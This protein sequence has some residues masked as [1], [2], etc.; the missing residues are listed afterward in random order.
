MSRLEFLAKGRARL[1]RLRNGAFF[2][3]AR[4]RLLGF[5]RLEIRNLLAVVT[6]AP[7]VDTTLYQES[8]R[9]LANGLG[10]SIFA[11]VT[12]DR[13]QNLLRRALLKFDVSSQIPAGA[14]INSV[15]LRLN[16]TKTPNPVIS[17]SM[18][19]HEVLADWGEGT[20]NAGGQ[21]GTGEDATANSATWKHRFFPST[22]WTSLGGDFN[23]KVSS[24]TSVLGLGSY[25]WT[26]AGLVTDVQKW[27][28]T[29]GSQFG[30][31]LKATNET[32]SKNAKRFASANNNNQG[33]RP[34]L[35]VDFTPVAVSNKAPT[36]DLIAN[37]AAIL[38]DA[39]AQT[40]NLTGISAGP[41]ETQ[42]LTVTA[43]SNNTAL[44]PNPT[45]SYTSPSSTGSLVFTPV[46]NQS[47]T[48]TITVTVTDNGGT[49]NG[50]VD[51]LV[52]SFTVTVNPVNDAPTLDTIANPTAILEEAST[53][54]VNLTGISAGPSENQALSVTAVSNNTALIANPAVTYVSPGASG[55]LNYAPLPN[56]SGTAVITVT[57]ADN[58]GTANGGADTFVRS[59]TVTVNAVND[60]PALDAIANPAAI[61]EDAA[62]Q[63]INLSGI[64]A[65]PGE[66]Q[67]LTI[68]AVSNNPALIPNPTVNYTSPSSTGS[69]VF[70]PVANQSGTATITVTV[71]DNG[72]TANGGVESL[73]RSFT[74]T[75]NPVNDAPTLDAIAN[76]SA[77]L[78]DASAQTVNLTGISAGP[79][80]NQTITVSAVSSNT[81]LIAN[82]VVTYASPGANGTLNYTPIS[83]QFGTSV[84]TV[85]VADNGG[86]ANGG[87]DT[88]VRSFT[89]TVNPVNDAPT[90]D[91]IADPNP[92]LEDAAAQ[93][94]NLAGISAGPNENQSLSITAVSS[95]PALI[96]N[97][98]VNFT[99]PSATGTLVYT[100]VANQSGS[101]IITVTVT[102]NGGIANG[103]SDSTV[104]SF[105]VTVNAVN[106]APTL[107]A[108]ANP[109]AILEDSGVQT[110]NLAGISAGPNEA[111][112]LSITAV[113]NNPSLIPNPSVSYVSPNVTGSLSYTPVA[114]QFGSA[115]IVVTVNDNGGT[116][117]NGVASLSRTFTVT[118]DPVNDS[119]TLDAISNPAPILEDATV[120]TI[121]LAGIG[122]GPNESQTVSIT[123]SSSNIALIANP[124]IVYTSPNAAG[125]L[126]YTPVA[127]QSGTAI[128]TVTAKDS[129]GTNNGGIDSVSRTFTVTVNSVNDAPTLDSIA[130]P[131]AIL[132]DAKEQ[133]LSLAG[134]SA[135]PNETQ[136][137]SISAVS[138]NPT[139]IPNPTVTYVSPNATGSLAFTPVA[140]Q[141]GAATITVTVT[142]NGGTADNGQNTFT[143]TFAV[144]VTPVN[145]AP[146]LDLINSPAPILEN[147][148]TQ[149]VHLSGISAGPIE[150]Q[151][152][153]VTAVSSNPA[154]TPNPIVAYTS[155]NSTG[156]LTYSPVANQ[157]GTAT[158]T[159]TV[160]DNGGT[161]N[162]GVNQIVRTFVVT[163][164]LVNRAPTLDAVPNPTAILEDAGA[165]TVSLTGI[166]AG[167][168]ETQTITVSAASSNPTLIPQ[169][170]V[171]YTSPGAVGSLT[172]TPSANQSGSAVITV[173]VQ[174]NGGTAGGGI[175]TV[176]RSFTVSVEPV[177]DAPTLDAIANPATVQEGAGVQTIN[178]SGITAGPNESQTLVITAVSNNTALIP[179]PTVNYTSPNASGSLTYTPVINQSGS[180]I[181]TVTVTDNGGKANGGVD[182]FVRT[183]RVTVNDVNHAPTLDAIPNPATIL[184]DAGLQL[185]GLTGISAG[186]DEVQALTISA[187]SS[188]TALI[189]HPTVVY[190]SPDSKG[191][192]EFIPAANQSGTAV[193]TVTLR[194]DGGTA[195]GGVDSITRSFTVTVN[196]VNDAPTL[197]AIS[198]PPA[199]LEGA[200]TQ[201]IQMAGITAGPN[202]TQSLKVSAV[203]SNT[204]LIPNPAVIYTS[205]NATGS[206]TYTPAAD[207]AGTA[208]I[209]VT[210]QD[211]GGTANGGNDSFTRTFTVTVES[212]ND[213]PTLDAIAN[214]AA[215][216]EDATSQT[217]S[218]TGIS[219]GPNESQA[220]SITAVSSNPNLISNPTVTY[221]SPNATASLKYVPVPN[222]FGSATIS[223]TLKDDGG[224]SNGG[225]D[226][227]TRSFTI[228]VNP[229]NDAPT[230]DAIP[231]P[232]AVRTDQGVQSLNLAGISAGPFESQSL[233]VSAISSNPSL[234]GQPTIDYTSPNAN[235]KLSFAPVGN[236]AGKATITVTV[237]D[238]GGTDNG[239]ANSVSRDFVVEVI[240]VN[241]L[242]TIDVIANP[243]AIN[244]D[245]ASQKITL[246][247]ITAGTGESQ[248]IFIAVTSDNPNV[249]P[250]PVV[251]YTSPQTTGSLAYTPVANKFGSAV[252]TVTVTDGGL[253]KNLATTLDNASVNRQF[254]VT[255]NSVNDAPVAVADAFQLTED[256]LAVIDL[257]AND[258]DVDSA[259]NTSSFEFKLGP[260]HG[261]VSVT[262]NGKVEYRPAQDYFG[263]DGFSY[264]VADAQG[265]FSDWATVNL[266][267]NAIPVAAGELQYLNAGA[268]TN[269]NVLANDRDPDGTAQDLQIVIVS[270][271]DP[272]VGQFVVTTDKLVRF[273]PGQAFAGSVQLRY[274]V[275]DALGAESPEA[276]ASLGVFNQN[277]RISEDVNDSGQITPLDVLFIINTLNVEGGRRIAPGSHLAPFYDVNAD[278]FV[279]PLDALLIINFLNL[280]LITG[281]GESQLNQ[282]IV[283]WP[284]DHFRTDSSLGDDLVFEAEERKPDVLDSLLS[285]PI[286]VLVQSSNL[287][288][289]SAPRSSKHAA[290]DV[291]FQDIDALM[292][293]ALAMDWD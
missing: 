90:L 230:L 62:A 113:S 115:T 202:E 126:S 22:N 147:S 281:E 152:L 236:Q 102:D 257:L 275:R 247:G 118:V 273:T 289:T 21:E 64:S 30:W 258:S 192:L 32:T 16:L 282:T 244:E 178:L 25:E 251:T 44:I 234:I 283:P 116:A 103:G 191:N 255:V 8:E 63:T 238:N 186:P 204:A 122:A 73:V 65:G 235:G 158:I 267:I 164:S 286:H 206:L 287:T 216:L 119:P 80:E 96:P 199:I 176:T 253:D 252:I 98:T 124:A 196:P 1:R 127:N 170:T 18:S 249:I 213:V 93:T 174:D 131:A 163:V 256:T 198:D 222:Q 157:T 270:N 231:N 187:Q 57:V 88:F 56:Q 105:T 207:Q 276:I 15:T 274:R 220:L 280:R 211:D 10:D 193:I 133:T 145:D 77:T 140:N 217:V 165:Q 260:N 279:S 85:T 7:S 19:L 70:T 139:L 106:D 125:T 263:I 151:T 161:T 205:A 290:S 76:P 243:A 142:D 34:L 179:N 190:T 229:V 183:F 226:S 129:G 53:Q 242:P 141:S 271:P 189:P 13:N 153:S 45:V 154:L 81:A 110:V 38:E 175:D 212:I 36:L 84:I 264:R 136:T 48:A 41:G 28:N 188:N 237:Q 91:V 49:A 200:T 269:I 143:R 227:I 66:T 218:L 172:Y 75:V 185:V 155:P 74:V 223:V 180:A 78:E 293:D 47:G 72:G 95:N 168:N 104:R 112:T 137:L 246:T 109:A 46:A 167:T 89:I 265:A 83:N 209:T 67:T 100:P 277:P 43:V 240:V 135:G 201:T 241:E 55:T 259:F 233:T 144:T 114:N 228:T 156:S 182:S 58:G 219:A 150:A 5:E 284:V 138:S 159:V 121:N 173:T 111:Q 123:A 87:A 59:F 166:S 184:E 2:K 3:S 197:D 27:V 250:N 208:V 285:Q 26:G 60:A 71:T 210:V 61:L 39:A 11:G 132:E 181:V 162:G 68:T 134:I 171:N 12:A 149:T 232:A 33:N 195:N 194:D 31:L 97:P 14:T 120:Q 52:R 50:G 42:T 101:A 92:I 17:T 69:L 224:T 20:T 254:T 82:P 117:N 29:P 221:T 248:P 169:P 51:T 245:S 261:T 272:S 146:T 288:A 4:R 128:I 37:P 160:S 6:F 94:V 292:V 268:P 35:T 23:S 24:S 225:V 262:A 215:I 203:S 40:V 266:A 54:T 108:I 177:N 99:S 107:D 86:T 278:G 148:G 79:N 239:G 9:D 291:V 130:D 214:P